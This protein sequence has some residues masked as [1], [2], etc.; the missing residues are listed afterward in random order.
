MQYAMLTFAVILL[1]VNFSFN[2]IYQKKAGTTLSAALYFN[3][4]SG[5]FTAV[6]F[7]V[8]NGFR[9]EFSTYSFIMSTML[10]MF[11]MFYTIIGFKIMENGAMALYTLFLMSGGMLVPYV[12]GLAFLDEQFSVIRGIGLGVILLGVILPNISKNVNLKQL[13]M[14]STVFFLNGFVSVV[15]KVHQIEMV[16]NTIDTQSFVL[17]GGIIKFVLSGILWLIIQKNN[18]NKVFEK[19]KFRFL[20]LVI[21]SVLVSGTSSFLQL[22]S[23]KSLPAT[24]LYPFITGG[25]IVF[26]GLAGVIFFK[27]KLSKK[28]ILSVAMCFI[29][30]LMFL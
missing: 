26:S 21:L 27:D 19:Q 28:L 17:T 8:A 9:L 7:F 23:A 15:S 2:K 29:G 22:W 25:T 1:A 12:W 20:P 24:V 4:L 10:T 6:V 18:V 5:F 16:Y 14:C 11:G 3:C 30:T 13:I